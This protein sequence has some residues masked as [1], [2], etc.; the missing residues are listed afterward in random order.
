MT[1]EEA[2]FSDG[3]N[4]IPKEDEDEDDIGT[5]GEG[6]T[7]EDK[8]GGEDGE[9]AASE[10]GTISSHPLATN[11]RNIQD[12]DDEGGSK[13]GESGDDNDE[14][15]DVSDTVDEGK[16]EHEISPANEGISPSV[17]NVFPEE[18]GILP[19]FLDATCSVSVESNVECALANSGIQIGDFGR[20][21]NTAHQVFGKMLTPTLAT[22]SVSEVA[23]ENME[24]LESDKGE[25]EGEDEDEG[26]D[27]VLKCPVGTRVPMDVLQPFT[28]KSTGRITKSWAN[29]V[30]SDSLTKVKSGITSN[31]P[32][33][34]G[35]TQGEELRFPAK[36][37]KALWF[38]PPS[39]PISDG[40]T[41]VSGPLPRIFISELI[42]DEISPQAQ[43]CSRRFS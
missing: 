9:E 17:R 25:I 19:S 20:M 18:C 39:L 15:S 6:D 2:A 37:L 40:G 32:R 43:V 10:Q 14:G 38:S 27:I 1:A 8:N 4:S 41:G 28:E 11:G 12:E 16:P 33:S 36:K 26:I 42:V 21:P 5:V 7:E 31:Q 29:I 35:Y 3:D 22:V 34:Q 24:D 30:A 23:V 13:E